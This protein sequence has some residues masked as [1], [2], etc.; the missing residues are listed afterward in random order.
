VVDCEA[1]V[2]DWD[3]VG[4]EIDEILSSFTFRAV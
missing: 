3:A 4:D 2:G 1:R